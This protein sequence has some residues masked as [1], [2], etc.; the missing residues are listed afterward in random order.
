MRIIAGQ[1]RGRRLEAVTAQGIQAHI[2]PG[3]GSCL[4][5]LLPVRIFGVHGFWIFLPAPGHWEL[6]H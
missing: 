6:R 2:G 1:Y 3:E 5:T 4:S